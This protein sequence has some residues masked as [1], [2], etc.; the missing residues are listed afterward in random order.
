MFSFFCFFSP[1]Y[2]FSV[3]HTDFQY[4]FLAQRLKW[5]FNVSNCIHLTCKQESTRGINFFFVVEY[6]I[7]YLVAFSVKVYFFYTCAFEHN[8]K[9]LSLGLFSRK[10]CAFSWCVF[11]ILARTEIFCFIIMHG[12]KFRSFQLFKQSF[13]SCFDSLAHILNTAL[14]LP[15]SKEFQVLCF[16]SLWAQYTIYL[17]QKATIKER[18]KKSM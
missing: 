1:F 16:S 5:K 13:W 9:S 17:S 4:F 6:F 11:F 18:R 8:M 7:G 12:W 10:L 14:I 15:L 2:A 3:S